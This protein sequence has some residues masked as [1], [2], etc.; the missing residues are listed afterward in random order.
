MVAGR[1]SGVNLPEQFMNGLRPFH[2]SMRRR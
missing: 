2:S 1:Q